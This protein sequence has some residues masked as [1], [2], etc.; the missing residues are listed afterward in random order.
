MRIRGSEKSKDL[1]KKFQ[2][3]PKGTFIGLDNYNN[4][5]VFEERGVVMIEHHSQGGKYRIDGLRVPKGSRDAEVRN[6]ELSFEYR[7]QKYSIKGF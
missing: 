6:G 2:D 7:G 3:L 5:H 4:I 1:L